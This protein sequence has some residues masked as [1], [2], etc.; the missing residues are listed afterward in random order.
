MRYA[1]ILPALAAAA[2]AQSG[3]VSLPLAQ[4]L[5]NHYISNNTVSLCPFPLL[6]SCQLLTLTPFQPGQPRNGRPR[7]RDRPASPGHHPASSHH[8][9]ARGCNYS[10]SR[11]HISTSSC[12]RPSRRKLYLCVSTRHSAH[13]LSWQRLFQHQWD[14]QLGEP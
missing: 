1:I 6:S 3:T 14:G 11:C 13:S 9:S 2:L 4:H 5:S 12:C 8:H 7:R 10:A